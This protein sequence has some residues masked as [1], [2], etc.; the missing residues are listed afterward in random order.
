MRRSLIGAATLVAAFGFWNP[1]AGAQEPSVQPMLDR[2]CLTCHT[3]SG[4]RAGSVPI[5]LEALDAADVA[6]HAEACEKVVAKLRSGMMPPAGRPRPDA[7]TYDTVAG[8][9]EAELDRT[10]AADPNPGRTTVHRLNRVEYSNAVRDLLGLEVDPEALLPPD[11]EDE[12]FENIADV[13]SVSPTLMERYLAA[14]R[15]ISQLAVGDPGLRPR[16]ETYR[17]P[18]RQ[19]QDGRTTD[20]LPFGTRGGT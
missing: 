6:A 1:E 15:R 8:W 5:S 20:E 18:D 13:L 14:A 10:A 19:L 4:H 17:L 12:G 2:Y 11:D 7:A 3:D 9:L 16:Y